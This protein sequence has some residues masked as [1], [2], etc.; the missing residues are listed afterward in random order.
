MTD[1]SRPSST[2][3][4][5]ALARYNILD[6]APED[7]F[8]RL[9]DL[10]ARLFDAAGALITFIDAERQWYKAR[11]GVPATEHPLEAS[12]CVHT[13]RQDDI[14]VV[15]DLTAD[16]RFDLPPLLDD[17]TPVRFYAGAPLITPDGYRLGALC[18]L[19]DTP[20]PPAAVSAADRKTL[21]DLAA[22]VMD[23]LDY[24]AAH[25]HR[26]D[27]L[28][29]ITDA[30]F[31]V[32]RNW[33][34]TYL[35][36]R[37]E[38]LLQRSR[39][40]LIGQNVW[41]E[42]PEAVDL[43]F[44]EEYH[45]AVDTQTSVQFD[46][47]FPPLETW[48]EV[49]A[50]PMDDGGLS[51]YFNDV[52]ERK[53]N[54]EHLRR[55]SQAI[56]QV[57]ESIV[58]TEGAPLDPP[59]P[60]IKYVNPAFERMTGYTADEVIGQTPRVLH[61][62]DT[63]PAVLDS[64]R[65]ALEK[66]Q[67]W[68]G[69]TVNYRKDGTPFTVRWNVAPVHAPDGSIAHWVSAQRDVS[70]ERA[71]E[72]A[73][74]EREEYLSVT[75]NSIGDAVIATD[76][77]GCITEMN[78]VAQELTGWTYEEARGQPLAAVFPLHNA[79]TGAPVESP[80]DVVLREGHTVGMANHTVLTAR[81]GTTHHI[82][83]SA[84]PTRTADGTLLGVVMVFR[85]V[86]EAYQRREALKEERERLALALDGADLGMWDLNMNTGHTVYND[87]WA[88]MLG[89]T[90]DDIKPTEAF[91]ESL[92]HPDDLPRI[93][94]AIE[95]HA[96]GEISGID[97]EIRLRARD[98]S[99]RWVLD[100]GKILEWNDDGTPR[101][102]VGTHLD[103]TERKQATETLQR[104]QK[105]LQNIFEASPAAIVTL[106][107]EGVF[108]FASAR[109]EDVLGVT[110][111][112]LQGRTYNDTAWNLTAVDEGSIGDEELPFRRV[113]DTGHPVH[114]QELA[115]SWPDGTRRVLSI[116]GAPLRDANGH[117][118]GAVFVLDD[119]TEARAARRE[120]LHSRE[121]LA[122]A[123]EL[124]NLGS[125]ERDFVRETLYWSDETRRIFGYDAQATITFEGFMARVHPDDRARL[126][127][128][129]RHAIDS[130]DT[131]DVEYRICRPDGETRIVHERGAVDTAQ[132]GT[133]LRLT[134]TVLDIT[135]RKRRE[136][137]LIAAKETAE[138]MNQLKSAF[139]AN[140]SH[141]IRTPLTS[142]IG[143][144]E[145][146]A[147]MELGDAPHR[148]ASIINRS[149]KRL[150]ETLNSVLDL[151]QLEAGSLR[152]HTEAVDATAEV[153]E[154]VESF[155]AQAARNDVRLAFQR[156]DHAVQLHADRAALQRV[157]SNLVSNALKF[158]PPD[159]R[160]TVA[161]AQTDG[162][163]VL[164]VADTGVG[165]GE[166]FLPQLFE[167]FK[168]EST[169]DTRAFEGTGLGLTITKRLIDLMDGSIAVES[170]KGQGTTFTVKLPAAT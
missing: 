55:L 143:F 68:R 160:V 130:G 118:Y 39:E 43:P 70:Q 34:F 129:Q 51:V 158:T 93:H 96:Q 169:G 135:E 142:I 25:Q 63:D 37:A 3:R 109:V 99:W 88:H 102:M 115:L 52:T 104:E 15:P 91:F 64:L 13:I 79:Q 69:E 87:H 167:A 47:Y 170:T 23:T 26:L 58:I 141:E 146:L 133:P 17:E 54:E 153:R 46:A 7:A 42:F 114:D 127:M 162:R 126:R 59:G 20:R 89:Y 144:A 121:R 24:R 147:D 100:R 6:S 131:L 1:P 60:R 132:D 122:R 82:A 71:M 44:Y 151:S 111:E 148:F 83:D 120:L 92:V 86:T 72:R 136:E 35:N 81:D 105:L 106:D 9:T 32:D 78:A 28:E 84:A 107:A 98:G 31:A 73:L 50:F 139:L 94:A 119:I 45:R 48:F 30:F 11:V 16:D 117:L 21:R 164:S 12:V 168:Q 4:L 80:V 108:T 57:N 62:P 67:S 49:S 75:L 38:T 101:R 19:D 140:M 2:R 113:M 150:L 41:E 56:E 18:V 128:Q 77:D 85:D 95:R 110:P 33:R 156:P 66:G 90:L 8:D 27:V 163:G 65:G 161:L 145:A 165:I 154:V 76:P 5:R 134:G 137:E 53:D 61:G 74:R 29:S 116:N 125:W 112:V 138:E 36:E 14:F 155:V 124:I 159:G 10:A 97:L 40:E 123:Q 152:L 166:D 103:I 157:V 149:G 22:V